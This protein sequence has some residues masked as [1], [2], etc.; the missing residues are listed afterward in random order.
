MSA[1]DNRL[2]IDIPDF[3]PT[4]AEL[5]EFKSDQKLT[6]ELNQFEVW[7]VQRAAMQIS[8][9]HALH[10]CDVEKAADGLIE[11]VNT[12]IDEQIEGR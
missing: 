6:L 5:E 8:H 12:A 7:I 2:H 4:D 3:V 9:Q 10:E 11:K 1:D